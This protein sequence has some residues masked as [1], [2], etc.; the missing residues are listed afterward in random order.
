[1]TQPKNNKRP[2]GK[3]GD[4]IPGTYLV[5]DYCMICDEA[6]R[7]SPKGVLG[8][9]TCEICGDHRGRP[10]TRIDRQRLGMGKINKEW[11]DGGV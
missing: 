11:I 10:G 2:L 1:M 8:I 3:P 7:A 6:I 4:R 5:R 9:N